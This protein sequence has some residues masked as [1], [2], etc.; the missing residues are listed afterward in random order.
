MCYGCWMESGKPNIRNERV[1][2]AAK[3]VTALYGEHFAG[4]KMHIVTD[5]WNCEDSNVAF[6]ADLIAKEGGD[7]LEKECLAAFQALSD[8]ERVSALALEH[9]WLDNDPHP[10]LSAAERESPK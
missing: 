10:E 6:C 7:D 1:E 8:D 3:A 4:G 2:R 9:G 5:D